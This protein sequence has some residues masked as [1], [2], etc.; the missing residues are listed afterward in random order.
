LQSSP[1]TGSEDRFVAWLEAK[2]ARLNP[3]LDFFSKD[4]L[5]TPTSSE[6][7]GVKALMAIKKGNLLM[8]KT[9]PLSI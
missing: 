8:T 5:T 4:L 9:I 3:D 6:Y 1:R 7:R 2:G